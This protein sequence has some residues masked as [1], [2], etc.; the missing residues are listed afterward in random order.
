MP[1]LEDSIKQVTDNWAVKLSTDL[2][3]S[4]NKALKEGGSTNPNPSALQFNP[5]ITTTKDGI[6]IEIVS[7]YEYW[8]WVEY[9][10]KKGKMPPPEVFGKKWQNKLGINA[11]KVIAEINIK[12]G[13]KSKPKKIN[14]DRNVKTLSFLIARSVGKKGYKARPFIDRIINDGRITTLTEQLAKVIGQNLTTELTIGA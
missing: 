8:Y 5:V 13:I 2:L 12:K 1:N 11:N 9:G 7:N 4:L 14:Y 3:D 6:K 10:R